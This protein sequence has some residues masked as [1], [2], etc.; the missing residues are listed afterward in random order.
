M[1]RQIKEV[2]LEPLI[3]AEVYSQQP[4]LTKADIEAAILLALKQIRLNMDYFGTDFP[5]PATKDNCYPIMD[6]TEW[7]NGFWT[8]CLWLAYEYT[9]NDTI[10]SLAQANDLS[11]LERVTKDIELDHHDLGFLY[12]PSCMAEWKLLKTPE[13][14]LAAL[15]AADKL[16]ERYQEKGGFIQAWGKLGQKED[17]RLIIDCLLN[18][19]LLFFASQETGDDRYRQMATNHFYASA[20]NV[21]R[22]DASAYHTFYFDPETG[23]PIK[24]VTRQGYSDDS[25]WARGQAWG[26]YGIPLTYRFLKDPQLIALFK[27]MTHY[28]LNRLPKDQV[29]Y[30]DLIFEDSSGQSKDSSATAIAVCGIH[31]M[32]KHLPE[33][34]PDKKAYQAAM[35]CMLR[36]LIDSYANKDIKPGAPLLRHGVYSWH[37]GKGV[38][39]GN[40]WGDYYYLEALLRFYKDWTPYW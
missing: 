20:N 4:Y 14:R 10:K 9:G 5:R 40:I 2:T 31:E 34:D 37:S 16:I 13:A 30:W 1:T 23:E 29:S 11:F 28:F 24:G 35:H 32:L 12:S 17:Y 22:D 3:Q 6:N 8:G 15:K 19:Q 38:D 39:E 7:T 18:I 33:N 27:G 36:S 26:I 25:A 21:I